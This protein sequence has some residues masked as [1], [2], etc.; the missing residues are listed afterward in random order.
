MDIRSHSASLNWIVT[1][2]LSYSLLNGQM[3]HGKIMDSCLLRYCWENQADWSGSHNMLIRS[4]KTNTSFTIQGHP[5]G[6]PELD[7]PSLEALDLT[8]LATDIEK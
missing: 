3:E 8:L 2:S 7:E 5:M 1:T 6:S 4:I